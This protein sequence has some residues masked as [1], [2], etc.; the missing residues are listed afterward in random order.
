MIDRFIGLEIA[1]TY[2]S[3]SIEFQS[4]SFCNFVFT[5]DN[6]SHV[7]ATK[8]ALMQYFT[9]QAKESL[10]EREAK[11]IDINF[12]DSSQGLF[13]T[14]YL[15]TNYQPYFTGQ[16]KEKLGNSDLIKPIRD[17]VY[18]N[19]SDYFNKN[20]KELKIIT[21]RIKANAKARIAS[22]K[23]RNAVIKGETNNFDEFLMDNFVPANNR[24]KGSYRELFIIEGLSARGTVDSSRFDRDTQAVFS[25]RGV[26]LNSFGINLDK[27]LL[28]AEFNTLVKIL[29]CNIGT[30]FDITKLRYDKIIIMTDADSDGFP[31]E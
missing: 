28:N 18:K 23:I 8:T 24:G 15:R 12:N 16:T 10:S 27:V 30:R 3:T 29:G 6:G 1:F 7:D 19:I 25:M 13:L 26:P 17:I 14:V 22:T 21:D 2:S 11:K 20:P 4:E 9:R 31:R 5:V